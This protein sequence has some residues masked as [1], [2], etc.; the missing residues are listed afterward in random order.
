MALLSWSPVNTF[1]SPSEGAEFTVPA[2][3]SATHAFR[4]DERARPSGVHS[5]SH[6]ASIPPYPGDDVIACNRQ[7]ELASRLDPSGP[8]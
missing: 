7:P 3:R 2:I 5:L 8:S 4:G 1:F 6:G